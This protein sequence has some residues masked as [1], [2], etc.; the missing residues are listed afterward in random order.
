ML[1]A[2]FQEGA[3]KNPRAVGEAILNHLPKKAL[4]AG[5][6][7]LAGPGFINIKISPEWLAERITL[8]LKGEQASGLILIPP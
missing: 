6:P 4:I 7:T 3:P 5:T 8:M 2:F 1:L